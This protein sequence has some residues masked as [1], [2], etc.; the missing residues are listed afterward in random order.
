MRWN[1]DVSR[2]FLERI[3]I[4]KRKV[5]AISIDFVYQLRR[6][7]L[8]GTVRRLDYK[9]QKTLGGIER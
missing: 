4:V 2:E 9:Y 8:Y 1:F 3:C 7:Y 6:W 5:F